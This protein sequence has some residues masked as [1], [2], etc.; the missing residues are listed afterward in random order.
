[1]HLQLKSTFSQESFSI[2]VKYGFIQGFSEDYPVKGSVHNRRRSAPPEVGNSMYS[3]QHM[4]ANTKAS[5]TSSE[6]FPTTST[7]TTTVCNEAKVIARTSSSSAEGMTNEQ[8]RKWLL[9]E[10][11]NCRPCNYQAFKTD[12]CRKG[13]ACEFCHF[14]TRKDRRAKKRKS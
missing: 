1:M 2:A 12:G 9:H 6:I 4:S 13:A 10:S 11:G 8:Q 5:C 3:K 7:E 14:D